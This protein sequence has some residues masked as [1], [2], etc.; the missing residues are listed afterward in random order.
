MKERK[1]WLPF[2]PG[3]NITDHKDTVVCE[4]HW[5]VD[6]PNVI[7]YMKERPRDSIFLCKDCQVRN[8]MMVL[9]V[10]EVYRLHLSN[11]LPIKHCQVH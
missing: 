8:K 9:P 5:P 7:Y 1:L 6:Y 2:I 4:E 3:D 11:F 10:D